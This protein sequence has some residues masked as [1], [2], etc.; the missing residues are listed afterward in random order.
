VQTFHFRWLPTQLFISKCQ[1]ILYLD[2]I[3]SSPKTRTPE[4]QIEAPRA[5]AKQGGKAPLGSIPVRKLKENRLLRLKNGARQDL[6]SESVTPVDE[7]SKA[8]F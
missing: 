3:S 7:L 5:H 1:L 4:K 8:T 6:S 2:R